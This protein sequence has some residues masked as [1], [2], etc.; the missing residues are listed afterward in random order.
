MEL[1][2]LAGDARI[3]KSRLEHNVVSIVPSGHGAVVGPGLAWPQ[4]L[5]TSA[6]GHE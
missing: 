6:Q 5:K 3:G 1:R 2:A 4:R